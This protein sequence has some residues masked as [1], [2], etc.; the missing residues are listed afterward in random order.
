VTGSRFHL[1]LSFVCDHVSAA[2]IH[3]C[4]DSY[5]G[6]RHRFDFGCSIGLEPIRGGCGKTYSNEIKV[7]DGSF[8]EG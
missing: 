8:T 3:R 7:S 4:R 5:R 1:S 2:E 6:N